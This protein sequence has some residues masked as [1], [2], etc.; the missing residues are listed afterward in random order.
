MSFWWN[1]LEA[2]EVKKNPTHKF[3]TAGSFNEQRESDLT[4][5][6]QIGPRFLQ[7]HLLKTHFC[8]AVG[9]SEGIK[10]PVIYIIDGDISIPTTGST[11]ILLWYHSQR[12]GEL[13][14]FLK[15]YFWFFFFS[16]S[17][18]STLSVCCLSLYL[19]VSGHVS[20]FMCRKTLS[21]LISWLQNKLKY[22]KS[23]HSQSTPRCGQMLFYF[24]GNCF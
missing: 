10:N 21:I 9:F 2:S 5:C 15:F 1:T 24:R 23:L 18:S 17:I 19:Q 16:E 14:F 6:I 22:V 11:G 8:L 4:I 12:E 7:S 3:S 20:L 13:L